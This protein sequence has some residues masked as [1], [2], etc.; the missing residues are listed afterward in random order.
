MYVNFKEVFES[1]STFIKGFKIMA[2]ADNKKIEVLLL[3][4]TYLS[5][6]L[7]YFKSEKAKLST[8]KKSLGIK[9]SFIL[10]NYSIE[11]FGLNLSDQKN[12]E[13]DLGKL[14]DKFIDK[15]YDFILIIGNIPKFTKYKN[16]HKNYSLIYKK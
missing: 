12:P 15:N 4:K 10:H 16:L 14:L 2:H 8:F 13:K 9:T 5:S 6:S 11:I 1:H 3:G 7:S